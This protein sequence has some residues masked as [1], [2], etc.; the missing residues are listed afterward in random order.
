VRPGDRMPGVAR[1]N[2]KLDAA[3]RPH[4]AWRF[5]LNLAAHSA[6]FVRG[7]E[8]NRHTPDGV[9][10]TGS[11][12]VAGYA[13]LNL[14]ADWTPVP[15][16]TIGLKLSNALNR[17]IATGG[18]LAQT[19]FTPQGVLLPPAEWRQAQFVAPGAGRAVGVTLQLAM[20]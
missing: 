18:L 9:T 6:S 11:G 7:N 17:H 12:R 8:N 20:P 14:S 1:H 5:G 4:E 13:L 15:G 10:F 3:W 2:L 16:W 19:A